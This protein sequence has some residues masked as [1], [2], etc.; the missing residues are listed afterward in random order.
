MQDGVVG[1]LGLVGAVERQRCAHSAV[2]VGADPGIFVGESPSLNRSAAFTLQ[3]RADDGAIDIGLSKQ[4]IL[5]GQAAGVQRQGNVEFRD[6]NLQAERGQARN[7]RSDGGG[8]EI[9]LRD[10]HLETDAVDGDAA[11]TKILDDGVDRVGLA[12]EPFSSIIVVEKE[13]L[14]IGF[15]CLAKSLLDIG[16]AVVRESDGRPVVP[17]RVAKVAV[18]V[19][20]FVDYIPGED[21]AGVV[22]HHRGDVFLQQV[23]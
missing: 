20:S 1:G 15:M 10:M 12:V 6:V 23:G 7:I 13:R 4:I 9:E 16:W 21:L 17:G 14:R 3:A 18:F 5:R 2:G 19:E 8:V 11:V 22:L